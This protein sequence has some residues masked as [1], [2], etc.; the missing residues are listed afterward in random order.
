MVEGEI[1]EWIS[2]EFYVPLSKNIP[3]GIVECKFRCRP[4]ARWQVTNY[5]VPKL[6]IVK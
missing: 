2:Y 6:R 4:A 1:D 5:D 3:D